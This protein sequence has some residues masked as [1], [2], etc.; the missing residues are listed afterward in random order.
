MASSV[1]TPLEQ[2]L[3]QIAGV[4]QMTSF[5]GLGATSVTV[6]FDLSRNITGEGKRADAV[7]PAFFT[8]LVYE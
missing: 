7:V 4:T 8:Q 5:S 2:Q 6:Q 3:G 1:A